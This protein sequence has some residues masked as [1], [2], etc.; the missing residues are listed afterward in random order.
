[1]RLL[2][3]VVLTLGLLFAPFQ[4]A[5]RSDAAAMT[6]AMANCPDKQCHCIEPDC[7]L[8]QAGGCRLQCG[9]PVAILYGGEATA[10]GLAVTCAQFVRLPL[11]PGLTAP[12]VRP[13]RA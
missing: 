2:L 5:G 7:G 10:P 3:G 6:Q 1:L 4:P 13:P 8:E 9:A 11:S 12:P